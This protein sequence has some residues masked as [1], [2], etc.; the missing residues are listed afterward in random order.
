MLTIASHSLLNIL[1]TIKDRCLIPTSKGPPTGMAWVG[2]SMV[3]WSGKDKLVTGVRLENKILK[4]SWT[5]Y[6]RVEI[7]GRGSCSVHVYR[8][9]FLCENRL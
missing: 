3:T 5:C 1:D 6:F 9:P 8:H 2:L 7:V 4:N